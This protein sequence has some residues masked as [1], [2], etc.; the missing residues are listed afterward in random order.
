ME[1]ERIQSR[2]NGGG[3]D[4]HNLSSGRCRHIGKSRCALRDSGHVILEIIAELLNNP[5]FL[6]WCLLGWCPRKLSVS[7]MISVE[8]GLGIPDFGL[9][10]G[11]LAC[12]VL[13]ISRAFG[14]RK[15][16]EDR[17]FLRVV[18]ALRLWPRCSRN[19]AVGG[20]NWLIH[21]ET[22]WRCFINREPV[23]RRGFGH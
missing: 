22:R 8:S 5:G 11:Q 18:E 20:S 23:R 7:L 10:V 19:T 6:R 4:T 15:I 1:A 12:V 21:G 9:P 14:V 17:V 3:D 16:C 13:Q 2:T